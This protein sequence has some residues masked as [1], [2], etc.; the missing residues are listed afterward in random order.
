MMPI[1][2]A[3]LRAFFLTLALWSAVLCAHAQTRMKIY[4]C[5]DASGAVTLQ[6]DVVCPKGSQQ[7]VRNIGVLTTMPASP[8]AAKPSAAAPTAPATVPVSPQPALQPPPPAVRS[9][10]QALF[11]CRTWDERDYLG[12]TAEPASSCVPVISVGID[13]SS[14]LAAGQT[15]EMRQDLCVAVPA[16]KL[17]ATWK[18]RVDEAEFRWKFGGGRNDDRKAEFDRIA[19]VYRESTCVGG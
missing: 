16:E 6:N 15:C 12:D 14:Q 2:T 1:R 17:C 7:S 19:K 10:P 13:G 8:A 9:A 18:K 4:R 11:Q 5:V 3:P